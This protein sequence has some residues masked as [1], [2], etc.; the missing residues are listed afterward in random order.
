MVRSGRNGSAGACGFRKFHGLLNGGQQCII[1]GRIRLIR[2]RG[3][4]WIDRER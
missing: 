4:K 3:L 1:F 2:Q